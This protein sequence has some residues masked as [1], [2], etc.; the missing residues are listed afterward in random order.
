[1]EQNAIPQI[2]KDVADLSAMIGASE[3]FKQ[4]IRSPLVKSAAQAAALTAIADKAGLN[5]L[6]KNFL[7][8]LAKNRRL[9][10]VENMLKAVTTSISARRG[11]LRAKV[12][13]AVELSAGQKKTLEES[14]A[15]TIGHPV[16]VDATVNKE[17]IGGVTVTLGSL[18][19]DDSIK[20]K[21]ERMGRA[22]KHN[23]AKAA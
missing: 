10:E 11:E 6:T 17:L 4:L 8:T 7:L 13:S 22:M 14:L 12:E 20:S 16:A 15:K 19:I 1:M 9:P 21:L 3:D 18:L 5:K 2:E 23:G